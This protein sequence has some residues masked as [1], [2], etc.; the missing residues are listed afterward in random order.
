MVQWA[1]PNHSPWL[2]NN[3]CHS[4]TRYSVVS[5]RHRRIWRSGDRT[6]WKILIIK[7]NRCTNSLN[8]FWNNTVHVSDSSS[9]DHHEFFTVHTA[10][11][12]VIQTCWQLA[13]RIRT[14]RSNSKTRSDGSRPDWPLPEAVITVVR[15]PDDGCQH[16]KHVE[17]PTEM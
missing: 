4:H 12:Y 1:N 6:S 8:L 17:L 3:C 7:P 15:T 10:T 14:E 16:T 2:H 9:V 11:V 5:Y 13:S